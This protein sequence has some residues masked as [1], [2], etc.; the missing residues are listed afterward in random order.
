MN[1]SFLTFVVVVRGGTDYTNTTH[2]VLSNFIFIFC[3]L[4]LNWKSFL[5]SKEVL[6]DYK[7]V[8]PHAE[9]PAINCNITFKNQCE[10]L[11]YLSNCS[12]NET[13][14]N[15]AL[16]SVYHSAHVRVFVMR[17]CVFDSLCPRDEL[18]DYLVVN[19]LVNEHARSVWT[20]LK[21]KSFRTN[22]Q[23]KM[24][25]Y[26]CRSLKTLKDIFLQI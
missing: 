17:I 14:D 12:V 8:F 16:I 22:T 19:W 10:T 23:R 3:R 18:A 7:T 15:G 2:T 26:S 13:S 5:L 6:V 24:Q 9:S 20:N 1:F 11:Q 4:I 25:S 21:T